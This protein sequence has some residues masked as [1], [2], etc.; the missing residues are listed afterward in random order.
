MRFQDDFSPIDLYSV[1]HFYLGKQHTNKTIVL[2]GQ[3]GTEGFSALHNKLKSVA[4]TNKINY[5]L[6]HYVKVS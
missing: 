4:E 5:I 2:Y 6:R 3:M 1:D